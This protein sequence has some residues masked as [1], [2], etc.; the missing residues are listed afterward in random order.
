MNNFT[1]ETNILKRLWYWPFVK[2]KV[3]ISIKK[4][5][6][7]RIT[8]GDMQNPVYVEVYASDK[9]KRTTTVFCGNQDDGFKRVRFKLTSGGK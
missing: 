3:T 6:I 8:Q 5:A 2:R 9:G 1:L 4:N 7:I